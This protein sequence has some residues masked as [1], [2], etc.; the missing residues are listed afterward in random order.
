MAA[1]VV[2]SPRKGEKPGVSVTQQSAPLERWVQQSPHDVDVVAT[3]FDDRHPPVSVTEQSHNTFW[4]ST[5]MFPQVLVMAFKEE[6]RVAEIKTTTR[7]VKQI[8]V[9]RLIPSQAFVNG[10]PQWKNVVSKELLDQRGKMQVE[11][12]MVNNLPTKFLRVTLASGYD[13]FAAVYSIR[14]DSDGG[15][16]GVQKSRAVAGLATS[17]SA[18]EAVKNTT[19]SAAAAAA[20]SAIPRA[21]PQPSRQCDRPGSL[22]SS[23]SSDNDLEPATAARP[24]APAAPRPPACPHRAVPVPPDVPARLSPPPPALLAPSAPGTSTKPLPKP[25]ASP[26]TPSV[27]LAEATLDDADFSGRSSASPAAPAPLEPKRHTPPPP[28]YVAPAPPAAPTAAEA[29]AARAAHRRSLS[30]QTGAAAR[31]LSAQLR[32][33]CGGC[34]EGAAEPVQRQCRMNR[35]LEKLAQLTGRRDSLTRLAPLLAAASAQQARDNGVALQTSDRLKSKFGERPYLTSNRDAVAAAADDTKVADAAR[36]RTRTCT[37][38]VEISTPAPEVPASKPSSCPAPAVAAFPRVISFR[39]KHASPRPAA[40]AALAAPAAA[41]PPYVVVQREGAWYQVSAEALQQQ[42]YVQMAAQMQAI[43]QSGC[44]PAQAQQAQWELY[45]Q[46]V[47]QQSQI[48]LQAQL[49]GGQAQQQQ[50]QQALRQQ[51]ATQMQQ[52]QQQLQQLQQQAAWTN[53]RPAKVDKKQ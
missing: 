13:H 25:P 48:A 6:I 19:R 36:P 16:E 18:V 43:Q 15:L 50:M 24:P 41:A 30:D 27:Q 3:S 11:V 12:H 26:E 8:L 1:A 33:D 20:A 31:T 14:R 46:Y 4:S 10:K 45:Q 29:A 51:W 21:C 22:S 23:A 38:P 40:A 35:R 7:N 44:S 53:A 47:V 42:L 17:P 52:Q 49:Y 34:P 5:G 28:P 37:H 2:K 9:D 39:R 32:T